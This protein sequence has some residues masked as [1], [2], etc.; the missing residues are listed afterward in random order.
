[1]MV[2]TAITLELISYHII[3][4]IDGRTVSKLEQTSLS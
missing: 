2:F 4:Y 1:M 3:S